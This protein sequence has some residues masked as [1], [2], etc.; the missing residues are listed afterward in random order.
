MK[1]DG[2]SWGIMRGP[3]RRQPANKH[4]H[5]MGKH[6]YARI[7]T[8]MHVYPRLCM[9]RICMHMHAQAQSGGSPRTSIA[10]LMGKYL[11]HGR[12]GI[13]PLTFFSLCPVHQI[14][15]GDGGAARRGNNNTMALP[16]GPVPSIAAREFPL[17]RSG[18]PPSL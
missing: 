11:H 5:L 16:M 6:A 18:S 17:N 3:V 10:I 15:L 8:R 9:I 12:A 1:H 7:F 13:S 14:L 2:A 4:R